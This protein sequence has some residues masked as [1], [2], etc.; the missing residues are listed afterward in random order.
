M[1]PETTPKKFVVWGHPHY[2]HTHSY[3]H[4]GFYKAAKYLG[5]D[6]D[7]LDNTPENEIKLKNT[8]TNGWLFLTEGQVDS[9]I[10]INPNAFYILHNCNG[11]KYVSVSLKNILII[12]VF[13]TDVITRNVV[14]INNNNFELWQSDG[15]VFYMPWATDILPEEINENIKNLKLKDNGE[16][17]FLGTYGGGIHGNCNEID[18]FR[19]KCNEKNIPF[20]LIPSTN[21]NQ[22][23]SIEIL[24]NGFI[25]PSIVGSWQKE[26]G[27]IPCRIFKTI[28]YGQLGVTNC[29]NAYELLNKLCVYNE[30]ESDLVDNAL[31]KINDFELRVKSMELVRDKHTYLSRIN[32]LQDIF[33]LKN[34]IV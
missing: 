32:S 15:N 33:K 10:P 2:T 21:I 23:K 13:T 8:D 22:E 1:W 29:K 25:T 20:N 24:K 14:P 27:Y 34:N 11:S 31:E 19:R 3:I 28:S 9:R 30:N 17:I 5:W 4:Y 16:A 12:Q 18:L 26:Q 6:V 7:W